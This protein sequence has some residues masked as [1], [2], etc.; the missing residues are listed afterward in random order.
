MIYLK[1]LKRI[2]KT[3]NKE[4]YDNE[5][6]IDHSYIIGSFGRDTAIK[7]VSDLDVVFAL[8]E[9]LYYTYNAYTSNGQS[10]LLQK[11]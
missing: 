9:D 3:L 10:A 6:E 1:K 2:V 7:G 8:P 4:L 11:T 5:S